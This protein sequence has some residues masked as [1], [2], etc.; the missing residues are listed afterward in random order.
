MENFKGQVRKFELY[1]VDSEQRW[2]TVKQGNAKD[3]TQISL[4]TVRCGGTAGKGLRQRSQRKGHS[5]SP[6]KRQ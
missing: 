4:P 3:R 2:K 1:F 5:S 6:P